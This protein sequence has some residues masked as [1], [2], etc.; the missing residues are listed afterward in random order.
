M[1][2]IDELS[3]AYRQ[4][5]AAIFA[6]DGLLIG[7][8]AGMG[9]D[10][11][12]PDFRGT[13]G[14]WR[15][16]PVF[17]GR[18]FEEISNPVW[19]HRDPEQAW[20]FFGHRLHLYRQTQPHPGFEILRRWGETRS[21]GYFVFTSNVDGQFQRAGFDPQRLIECH[22]SIHHLQCVAGCCDAIWSAAETQVAVDPESIRAAAPL[23]ACPHCGGLARPNVLMF[24]DGHWLAQR[25]EEQMTR[26]RAW[27]S[28]MRGKRLAVIELG[29]GHAVPTVRWEC[30]TRGGQLIRVN[31]RDDDVPPGGIRLP[32]GALEGLQQLD[33][34]IRRG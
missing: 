13:Q 20:G 8:G 10:S 29:A 9:V 12:L 25:S 16:Y 32:V 14:F 18:R 21:G 33:E 1:S 24:G 11:G 15:A 22:G 4:A 23:P 34:C 28:G 3:A 17:R 7:A 2:P 19:F 6:A 30:E 31:P 27:L 5:A 26:Y